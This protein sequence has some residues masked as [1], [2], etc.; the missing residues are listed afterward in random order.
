MVAGLAKKTM[1]SQEK[2]A[3]HPEPVWRSTANF[4]IFAKLNDGHWEQLWARQLSDNTF[5][6]CCIP[7]FAYDLGLGDDV[8]TGP[9]DD[10]RYVIQRVVRDA[11][12]Y[13][14]RVWFGN[15]HDESVRDEVL[16]K[17]AEL[18]CQTEWSSPNLLA[19]SASGEQAQAVADYLTAE[20]TRERLLYETG[21]S[22]E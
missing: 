15:S 20:S 1:T 7:F 4:L 17:A 5:Q 22:V 10:K 12:T 3:V 11:G 8:E 18:R 2:V 14:F 19:L 21:R 16:T 13:T 9:S 6:L